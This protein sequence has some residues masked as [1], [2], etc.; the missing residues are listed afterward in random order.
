[1]TPKIILTMP[2]GNSRLEADSARAF[3]CASTDPKLAGRVCKMDA[4][5]SLLTNGFN[6]LW[7][8]MLNSRKEYGWTHFAMIHSDVCP[9]DGWLDVLLAEMSAVQAD[10][11]SAVVPIKDSRGLTST[12]RDIG[13]PWHPRRLTLH[14]VWEKPETWTES[15]AELLLNTGLWVCRIG[16]WCEHVC[17]KQQDKITRK[18]DEFLPVTFSEDWD[19][20]R[21]C[22]GLGLKLYATRKLP[23]HHERPEWHTR[24]PWGLWKTDEHWVKNCG[25]GS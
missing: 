18:G 8:T 4:Q 21:Q 3:Y 15:G 25:G 13:G 22:H 7:A 14:E 17:F 10:V 12:A 11:L 19:F 6:G 1:M 20:S 2:R 24:G 9:P 5:S 16:E 23:L